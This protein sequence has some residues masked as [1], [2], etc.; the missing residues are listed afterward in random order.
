MH[1]PGVGVRFYAGTQ[2]QHEVRDHDFAR[3]FF[4][5]WLDPRTRNPEL[6]AQLLGAAAP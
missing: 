1:L 3:A 5:I 6:R 2:L 4:A